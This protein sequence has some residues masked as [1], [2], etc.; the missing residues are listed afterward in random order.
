MNLTRNWPKLNRTQPK[1]DPNS[2]QTQ[3][4][5]NPNSIQTQPELNPNST[6]TQPELD[7]NSTQ[8]QPEPQPELDPNSTWTSPLDWEMLLYVYT[9]YDECHKGLFS[10]GKNVLCVGL[11]SVSF[12]TTS[13]WHLKRRRKVGRE[14]QWQVYK[15]KEVRW[16]GYWS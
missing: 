7:P 11:Q 2:T 6:Q 4:K 13:Y 3:P 12:Q 14:E 1:L 16:H 8:T 15:E 9:I 10:E 5:L